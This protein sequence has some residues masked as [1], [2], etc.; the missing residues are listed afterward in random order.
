MRVVVD[1]LAD[2]M[3]NIDLGLQ[4]TEIDR[5]ISF[6][7]M[8]KSDHDQHFHISSNFDG[9]CRIGEFTFY[10]KDPNEPDD[11]H[12]LGR[13]LSPGDIIPL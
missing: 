12:L 11:I 4:P 6:L 10:V 8:L 9:A 7:E 3:F 1:E 13:A 5:L 2:N